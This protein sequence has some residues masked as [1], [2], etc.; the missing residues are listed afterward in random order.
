MKANS[1]IADVIK[2]GKNIAVLTVETLF[3][4]LRRRFS[5]QEV[6][7]QCY[8]IGNRSLLF[9][10][11]SLSFVGMVA[12]IQAGVQSQRLLGSFNFQEIGAVFLQLMIRESAPTI[13]ALMLA[14]RVGAGIAAEVGAMKVTEQVEALRMNEADPVDYIVAPRVIA[15]GLMMLVVSIYCVVIAEIA[16][17]LTASARFGGNFL[18]FFNMDR[19][20]VADLILGFSKAIIYGVSIPIVASEAGLSA[21]GGSAGVGDATTRAVVACSMVIIVEDFIISVFGFVFLLG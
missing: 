7:R 18:S 13:A 17:G 21:S 8:Y 5:L 2:T 1:A 4:I 15:C 12:V 10:M 6:I 20:E 11:G 16:G 14:T 3:S 9:V 19:I